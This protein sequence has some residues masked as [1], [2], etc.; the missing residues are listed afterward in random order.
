MT[1]QNLLPSS[2]ACMQVV[3]GVDH[4]CSG[5]H[6]Q[7][8]VLRKNDYGVATCARGERGRSC[9]RSVEVKWEGRGGGGGGSP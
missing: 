3:I 9:A 8:R 2:D 6:L 4:L 1:P 7:V 5:K